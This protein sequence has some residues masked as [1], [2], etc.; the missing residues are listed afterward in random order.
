MTTLRMVLYVLTAL[1][2]IWGF[3]S[4]ALL[5][6]P[7]PD[8]GCEW[9]AAALLFLLAEL[10]RYCDT[11]SRARLAAGRQAVWE[12]RLGT[13]YIEIKPEFRGFDRFG[14]DGIDD[15]DECVVCDG[16]HY[17]SAARVVRTAADGAPFAAWRASAMIPCPGCPTL[18][19][20]R[21]GA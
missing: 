20:H 19:I 21:V 14:L 8:L 5:D 18:I 16:K 7:L 2:T 12:R 6:N 10:V 15:A 13:A 11:R 4:L 3:I 17:V 1:C 9:A